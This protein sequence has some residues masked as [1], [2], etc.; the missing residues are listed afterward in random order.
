MN[1]LRYTASVMRQNLLTQL[2]CAR[3]VVLALGMGWG[4][5]S[6]GAVLAADK[7][8]PTTPANFQATVVGGDPA[9]TLTW[10]AATDAGGIKAYRVDRSLDQAGWNTLWVLVRPA[11]ARLRTRARTS[12]RWCS[13]LPGWW[14]PKLVV[15]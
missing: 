13:C 12:W 5:V 8:P 2:K 1:G 3:L 4:L 10:A 9:V 11:R 15:R 14:R 6:A 7:V